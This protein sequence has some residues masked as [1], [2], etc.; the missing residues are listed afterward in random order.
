MVNLWLY[1]DLIK[2]TAAEREVEERGGGG[3]LAPPRQS[4]TR[5]NTYHSKYEAL[6]QCCSPNGPTS[7]TS[8]RHK[9]NI[10]SM[11][12]VDWVWSQPIKLQTL[13][14]C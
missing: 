9:N 7:S 13:T 2:V 3:G 11:P 14:Q 4:D 10:G 5:E 8:A 6:T 1:F 12:R